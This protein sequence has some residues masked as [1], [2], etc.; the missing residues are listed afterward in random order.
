ML[1]WFAKLW[2]IDEEEYWGYITTCGTEG[3]LHGILV[4]RENLPDALLYA[5]QESHYSVFKAARMYRM[6]AVK[7]RWW[8][9]GTERGTALHGCGEGSSSGQATRVQSRDASDFR[10]Q[11]IELR[12][13]LKRLV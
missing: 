2:E 6:E 10:K 4:G 3:N 1:N 8:L 12:L 7:V 11:G 9:G 13:Q 5:S